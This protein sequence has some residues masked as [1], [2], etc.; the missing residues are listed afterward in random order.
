MLSWSLSPDFCGCRGGAPPELWK[1]DSDIWN[2]G[3]WNLE[4][5]I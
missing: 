1:L 5:E 4:S 3:T 2:P